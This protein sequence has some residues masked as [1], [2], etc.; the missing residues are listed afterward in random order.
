MPIITIASYTN[1]SISVNWSYPIDEAV[2]SFTISYSYKVAECRRSPDYSGHGNI[3]H[4]EK[5]VN[6]WDS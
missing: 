3:S 2:E 6:V 1:K 4:I 5:T